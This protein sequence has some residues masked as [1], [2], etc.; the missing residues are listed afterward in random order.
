MWMAFSL[1]SLGRFATRDCGPGLVC[2]QP[3]GFIKSPV[4]EKGQVS[5]VG[6]VGEST[7]DQ[8]V[9]SHSRNLLRK[10]D[11]AAANLGFRLKNSQPA[12]HLEALGGALWNTKMG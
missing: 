5:V 1:Q 10:H 7:P 3:I 9:A 11:R 6:K 4:F 8:S 2:G 12:P